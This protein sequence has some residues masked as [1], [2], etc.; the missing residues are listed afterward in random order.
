MRIDGTTGGV[1]DRIKGF[2][3]SG[4]RLGG[5]RV[6]LR[7]ATNIAERALGR[8]CATTQSPHH[9]MHEATHLS[10]AARAAPP[11][12]GLPGALRQRHILVVVVVHLPTRSALSPRLGR[13]H[14]PPLGL[15]LGLGR[16]LG[17][18]RPRL[19]VAIR[20]DE[21]VER[22]TRRHLRLSLCGVAP[23]KPAHCGLQRRLPHLVEVL[24]VEPD[25]HQRVVEQ[26]AVARVE[27]RL[28]RPAL[29]RH[30]VH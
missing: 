21:V 5:G 22:D 29:D 6:S 16:T 11:L 9:H 10:R 27:W 19:H 15:G 7:D 14:R 23:H 4:R 13:R 26:P 2:V 1:S 17:A 30:A 25:L 8:R 3:T 18:P 24:A 12:L 20:H 28:R